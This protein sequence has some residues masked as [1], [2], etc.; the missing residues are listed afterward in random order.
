[1]FAIAAMVAAVLS[2]FRLTKR[3]VRM[4][5][6]VAAAMVVTAAD[7]LGSASRHTPWRSV[8]VARRLF[9]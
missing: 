7:V 2:I 9:R 5:K 6:F 3:L 1:M 4:A 8:G